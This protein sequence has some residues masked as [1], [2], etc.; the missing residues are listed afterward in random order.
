MLKLLALITNK[1]LYLFI[2]SLVLLLAPYASVNAQAGERES[3]FRA[4]NIL[5]YDGGDYQCV[6]SVG[7]SIPPGNVYIVGDSITDGAR[8]YLKERFVSPWTMND[9]QINGVVNRRVG[10]GVEVINNDNVYVANSKAIIVE[11]GT[12]DFGSNFSSGIKDIIETIR[13]Y[14][15]TAPIFWVDIAITSGDATPGNSAIYGLAEEEGYTVV[16]WFKAVFPDSNPTSTVAPVD[17]KGYLDSV[18]VHPSSAGYGLLTQTIYDAISNTT[19]TASAS[20]IVPSGTDYAAKAFNF[21]IQKGLS[22]EQAAGILGNLIAESQVAGDRNLHA[23]NVQD[24]YTNNTGVED[25]EYDPLT[26]KYPSGIQAGYGIAQWTHISRK[27]RFKAFANATRKPDDEG[28]LYG[29]IDVQLDLIWFEFTGEPVVSGTSGGMFANALTDLRLTTNVEDATVVFHGEYEGSSA[30]QD[31]KNNPNPNKAAYE[32]AFR[33][34]INLAE[35]AYTKY[36][37]KFGGGTGCSDSNTNGLINTVT[38]YAWP[39]SVPRGSYLEIPPKQAYIDA[40]KAASLLPNFYGG[41]F[42][43][44]DCGAFVTRVM[45]DS[46]FDPNYNSYASNTPWQKRYLDENWRVVKINS[47]ADL[48]P[49]DVAMLIYPPG[50]SDS[51]SGHTYVYIGDVPGFETKVASSA[52]GSRSPASGREK[53]MDRDYIW[54]RRL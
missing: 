9:N 23:D 45:K 40:H 16:P 32:T 36:A 49:G 17:T 42:N 44:I 51:A 4:N 43:G 30:Y 12:N 39:N 41:G 19:T 37:G 54:Y 18:G 26:L 1:S 3:E 6:P 28:N 24:S 27:E 13:Q 20:S 7:T 10:E 25:G 34:R 33:P 31:Y 11:L 52:L 46:G 29:S 50:Y 14:N 5:F 53:V 47:T 15:A 22:N 48:L 21:F 2:S 8:S 38:S 35:E